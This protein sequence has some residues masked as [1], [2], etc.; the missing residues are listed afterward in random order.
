MLFS[1]SQ[2]TAAII[3]VLGLFVIPVVGAIAGLYLTQINQDLRQQASEGIYGSLTPT[4][5]KTASASGPCSTL[6]CPTG[7][8]TYVVTGNICT[9]GEAKK[10]DGAT[11]S[12][13]TDCASNNCQ[14]GPGGKYCFPAGV[15]FGK[16]KEGQTCATNAYDRECEAGLV[17]QSNKCIKVSAVKTTPIGSCLEEGTNCQGGRGYV[18]S[19]CGNGKVRC[20]AIPTPTPTPGYASVSPLTGETHLVNPDGKDQGANCSNDSECKSGNCNSF[21]NSFGQTVFLSENKCVPPDQVQH[22]SNVAANQADIVAAPVITASALAIPA[23][24]VAGAE[25]LALSG[26]SLSQIPTATYVYATN[27]LQT[28]PGWVSGGLTALNVA[29]DVASLYQLNEC[30]QQPQKEECG[31]LIASA[32]LGLIGQGIASVTDDALRLASN[33]YANLDNALGVGIDTLEPLKKPSFSR[34]ISQ[35]PDN[36]TPPE[37]ALWLAKQELG[38]YDWYYETRALTR[39]TNVGYQPG[40]AKPIYGSPSIEEALAN[41]D[42]PTGIINYMDDLAQNNL[43]TRRL[44][45]EVNQY[46]ENS[47]VPIISGGNS[48][49]TTTG[50]YVMADNT[51]FYWPF[52]DNNTFGVY[53]GN[54]YGQ[55]M[56]ADGVRWN[57]TYN[58]DYNFSPPDYTPTQDPVIL[59]NQDAITS[60][61]KNLQTT[62]HE[63]GHHVEQINPQ[64][65]QISPNQNNNLSTLVPSTE[66]LSSLYGIRASQWLS[67]TEGVETAAQHLLPQLMLNQWVTGN[68]FINLLQ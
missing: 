48:P 12:N 41:I 53:R 26:G 21:Y 7:Q 51:E 15:G 49:P 56:D 32:Q 24:A 10:T 62:V 3:K 40:V 6:A 5:T 25:I 55:F 16:I 33:Q 31:M 59:L 4:P 9:C 14:A 30:A 28:A 46:I 52:H 43:S 37:Q 19:S 11:C 47:G 38:A 68:P 27:A 63:F 67:Y 18:D 29:G 60:Q 20:G 35:M 45:T 58:P 8:Q 1:R 23:G 2:K 66:Y 65:I 17:C 64:I 34:F 42:D 54:N 39:W 61:N 50:R 36:L 57:A 44:L 22:E 13:N